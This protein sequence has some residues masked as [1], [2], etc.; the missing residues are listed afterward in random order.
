MLERRPCLLLAA[1]ANAASHCAELQEKLAKELRDL[2]AR[3][4][5]VEGD[6]N[7]D[8][9]QGL[10]VHLAWWVFRIPHEAV[11]FDPHQADLTA[12]SQFY[13]IPRSQQA[14]KHLQMAIGMLVD[15]GLDDDPDVLHRQRLHMHTS[16]D[17]NRSVEAQRASFGC[18]YLSSV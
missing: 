2:L 17:G 12:R 4:V 18:F 14:Y 6:T 1:V 3:Q 11:C 9:L 7:L 10:L 13:L 5:M 16:D 15:L 8:L